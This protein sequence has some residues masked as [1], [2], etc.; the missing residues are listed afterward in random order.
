[1][2]EVFDMQGLGAGTDA[3]LLSVWFDNKGKLNIVL[4]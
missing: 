3:T 1:V 2:P 4:L